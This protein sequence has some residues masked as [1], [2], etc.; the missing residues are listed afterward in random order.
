[1]EIR[2][3]ILASGSPRRK[4]LLE[5]IGIM[6][7]ISPSRIEEVVTS[8]VPEQ[9]VLELSSQK[10]EDVMSRCPVGSV[11]LGADTVVAIDGM[12]LGKP[13]SH[14]EACEMIRRIQGRS[15]QVHTGVAILLKEE[16]GLRQ[17]H[18]TVKTD[19]MVFPMTEEEIR[20]YGES[21]EP[22]DKAGAYAIQGRF[23]AYIQGISGDYSNVVGLPVGRVYQEL[24]ALLENRED[25]SHD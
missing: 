20:E 14:G 15:H 24:K 2:N 4:E 9:V 7:V 6:P 10:A 1:M 8:S 3:L 13:K 18:F 17:K 16:T 23:A 19:V 5:Q 12:I 21:E 25:E 22:M 11:V